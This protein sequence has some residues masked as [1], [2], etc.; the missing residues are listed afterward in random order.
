VGETGEEQTVKGH[1]HM[2]GGAA[3]WLA[4]SLAAHPSAVAVVG[5]S[6]TAALAAP[7]ADIDNPGAWSARRRYSKRRQPVRHRLSGWGWWPS[8]HRHPVKMRVS[9][10]VAM[11]GRHRE[12][13]AHSLIVAA[14]LAVAGLG[15]VFAFAPAVW[16]LPLAVG[17]G[18]GSHILLDRLNE[19]P[20]RWV[21]PFGRGGCLSLIRV[22][23]PG[24]A[25]LGVG[26][27]G[28]LAVEGWAT[29]RGYR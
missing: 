20:V 17:I 10:F 2:M 3:G 12:G 25:L 11:F 27:V 9:R 4:L 23:G 19:R 18:L 14:V 28:V 24:E 1:T 8:F 7:W 21:W 29:V 6:V 26:L 16:W 22:G 15:V 13:P 5:G